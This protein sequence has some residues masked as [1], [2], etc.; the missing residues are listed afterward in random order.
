MKE[1]NTLKFKKLL[2][3]YLE[4]NNLF[5]NKEIW[6]TVYHI[7]KEKGD[8]ADYRINDFIE[9][10][11]LGTKKQSSM[12][13]LWKYL[14]Q[15][16]ITLSYDIVV[17]FLS[18]PAQDDD[19][20]SYI[21]TIFSLY[22]NNKKEN[23]L[24]WSIIHQNKFLNKNINVIKNLFEEK[25][26][27]HEQKKYIVEYY[28]QYLKKENKFNNL[29]NKR[30]V[31]IL[32]NCLIK[33]FKIDLVGKKELIIN[34]KNVE[35]V[36]F[37]I[38]KK[39]LMQ[40]SLSLSDDF[41]NHLMQFFNKC[42]PEIPESETSEI[43]S[44]KI[45]FDKAIDGYDYAIFTKLKSDLINNIFKSYV[46]LYIKEIEKNPEK[47]KYSDIVEILKFSVLKSRKEYLNDKLLPKNI[48]T[49]TNKI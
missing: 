9:N 32:N 34:S 21:E 36:Y 5:L 22:T 29:E 45:G 1:E 43:I 15:K 12:Y 39:D 48:K 20:K 10:F 16:D 2:L 37:N 27:N 11:E 40:Y 47:P 31:S 6:N 17:S 30:I 26:L 38:F 41:S 42:L 18:Y 7:S 19:R 35:C 23:K 13:K 33:P 25:F 14:Y 46:D 8:R 49:N 24:L 28:L 4:T 3:E 44:R